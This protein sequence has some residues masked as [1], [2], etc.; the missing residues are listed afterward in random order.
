[1]TLTEA[2]KILRIGSDED[3]RPHLVGGQV[4]VGGQCPFAKYNALGSNSNTFVRNLVS[5]IGLLMREDPFLFNPGSDTP[6]QNEV[7]ENWIGKPFL[8]P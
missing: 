6:H 8:N 7:P 4:I 1:M 3:P 2:R 5:L